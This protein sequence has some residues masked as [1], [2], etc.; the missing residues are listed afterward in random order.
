[1]AELLAGAL[2]GSRLSVEVPPL[3]AP[4]GPPH[5][6][7]QFYI[8]IDPSA[9]DEGFLLR[10]E[11]LAEVIE[12]QPEARLPGRSRCIPETVEVDADLWKKIK[13]LSPRGNIYFNYLIVI[14]FINKT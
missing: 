5:D 6:L 2:T 8:V 7:G 12:S 1:M 9:Y 4:E 11:K 13:H 14:E 3:K 10:L